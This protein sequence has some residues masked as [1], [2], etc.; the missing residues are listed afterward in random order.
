MENALFANVKK[1]YDH[2]MYECVIPA[3]SIDQ[4]IPQ[5]PEIILIMPDARCRRAC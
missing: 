4:E 3:V 2:K 5:M 1:L